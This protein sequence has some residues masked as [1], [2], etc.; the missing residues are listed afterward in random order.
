[1]EPPSP[2]G[3]FEMAY[4]HP[5]FG[6]CLEMFGA[7][8]D[9]CCKDDSERQAFLRSCFSTEIQMQLGEC[10]LHPGLY[11]FGSCTESL[12]IRES[13]QRLSRGRC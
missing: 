10:L 11:V 6:G 9:R 5:D 2:P 13:S 4:V 1:M 3:P 8:V 7:Q 12:G